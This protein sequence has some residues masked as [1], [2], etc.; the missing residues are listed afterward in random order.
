MLQEALGLELWSMTD[1]IV[2]DN[3]IVTD[4]KEVH[5]KWVEQTWERKTA[6]EASRGAG[7]N[8]LLLCIS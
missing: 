3:F 5:S 8:N 7:V 6:A 1:E 4:D 2:F